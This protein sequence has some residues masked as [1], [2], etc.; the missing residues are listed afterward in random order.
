MV[1]G[2]MEKRHNNTTSTLE[3]ITSGLLLDIVLARG[4]TLTARP[5]STH[6]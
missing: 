3:E 1:W 4:Q 2:M 5:T 6:R